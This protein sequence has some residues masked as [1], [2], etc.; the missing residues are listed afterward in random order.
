MVAGQG[1]NV[2]MNNVDLATPKNTTQITE[3][4]IATL[5]AACAELVGI[6]FVNKSSKAAEKHATV[7]SQCNLI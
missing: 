1:P 6:D 7:S 3:G 5:M 2:P 4:Y